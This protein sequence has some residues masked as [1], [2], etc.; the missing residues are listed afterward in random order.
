MVLVRGI[1]IRLEL[2]NMR[3]LTIHIA[4]L[5][6]LLS[7]LSATETF[8]EFL[9]EPASLGSSG[10]INF[11]TMIDGEV[12]PTPTSDLVLQYFGSGSDSTNAVDKSGNG[13]DGTVS[14]ATLQA[15]TNGL[16]SSDNLAYGF[17]GND[18]IESDASLT[19]LS[20]TTVGTW[21][22]WAKADDATPSDFQELISYSD[23]SAN[24]YIATYMNQTD[25]K[26]KSF[27][28]NAGEILWNF[29]SGYVFEDNVWTH[30]VFVQDGTNVS[31]YVNGGFEAQ[32][33]GTNWFADLTGIDNGRIGATKVN[34]GADKNFW[35]GDLWGVEIHTNALTASEVLATNRSQAVELGILS[36]WLGADTSRL[37]RAVAN[38]CCNNNFQDF[39]GNSSTSP[40]LPALAGTPDIGWGSGNGVAEHLVITV[41]DGTNLMF[42][43]GATASTMTNYAVIDGA[44]YVNGSPQAFSNTF[45]ESTATS[46]VFWRYDGSNFYNGL[47]SQIHLGSWTTNDAISL[48]SYINANIDWNP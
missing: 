24:E 39:L 48:N 17:D 10:G 23:T 12:T 3:K 9:T 42:T 27:T 2:N 46:N 40:D 41:N 1:F 13:Y 19:S 20:G 11:Y 45:Y 28:R 14:G 35:V 5:L 43:A 6:M 8:Y 38:V 44:Q 29:D 22:I 36:G 26:L 32:T 15:V 30:I 21:S 37:D 31:Y 7:N 33:A 16:Y 25:G 47:I 4:L 18:Y 34:G